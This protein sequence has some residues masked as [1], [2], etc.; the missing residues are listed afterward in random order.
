MLTHIPCS[1]KLVT[2]VGDAQKSILFLKLLQ[3]VYSYGQG[4]TLTMVAL[5]C[6]GKS[7]KFLPRE[8]S[9]LPSMEIIITFAFLLSSCLIIFTLPIIQMLLM[10]EYILL[11]KDLPSPTLSVAMGIPQQQVVIHGWCGYIQ[12][13]RVVHGACIALF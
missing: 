11:E 2:S 10:A 6:W 13:W 9:W 4:I 7:Q 1:I 3:W 8:V 5:K 12:H